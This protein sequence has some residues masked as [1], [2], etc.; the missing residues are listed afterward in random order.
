[1]ETESEQNKEVTGSQSSLGCPEGPDSGQQWA[2]PQGNWDPRAQPIALKRQNSWALRRR[3]RPFLPTVHSYK[4][5]LGPIKEREATQA[6]HPPLG[7]RETAHCPGQIKSMPTC[8]LSST[9][10]NPRVKQ[11]QCVQATEH[12]QK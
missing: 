2:N 6:V 7:L 4:G 1:M 5:A 10:G 3:H 11:N 9:I 8:L 12:G